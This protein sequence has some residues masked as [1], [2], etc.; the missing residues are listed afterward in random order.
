MITDLNYYLR[1]KDTVPLL[2][3]KVKA[4]TTSVYF[5]CVPQIIPANVF[6]FSTAVDHPLNFVSKLKLWVVVSAEG[7]HGTFLLLLYLSGK[8]VWQQFG[9]LIPLL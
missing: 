5:V 8:I 1:L 6:H 3:M 9:H 2:L 4:I 7:K